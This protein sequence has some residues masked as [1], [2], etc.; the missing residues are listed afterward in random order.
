MWLFESHILY[1]IC[2]TDRFVLPR[3]LNFLANLFNHISATRFA[4][5]SPL[6]RII[7][8]FGNVLSVYFALGEMLGKFLCYLSSKLRNIDFSKILIHQS[9]DTAAHLPTFSASFIVKGKHLW[10]SR[11]S[12]RWAGEQNQ[13]ASTSTTF[14]QSEHLQQLWC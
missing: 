2:K 8:M 3:F 10:S 7:K 5:I 1:V 4:D 13:T 11:W 12:R 6:W 9:S 14:S